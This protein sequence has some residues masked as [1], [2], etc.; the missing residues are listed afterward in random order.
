MVAKETTTTMDQ[1]ARLLQEL[2]RLELI[3]HEI[4]LDDEASGEDTAME[5]ELLAERVRA[6]R[7]AG[8]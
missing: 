1:E 3:D 8:A 4:E 2:A 5:I 6:A 7:L